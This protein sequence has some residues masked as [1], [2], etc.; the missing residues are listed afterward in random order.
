MQ[1]K[2]ERSGSWLPF[3]GMGLIGAMIAFDA[4]YGEGGA[5]SGEL[6]AKRP[7][8]SA[9]E[10]V[11]PSESKSSIAGAIEAMGGANFGT[12]SDAA[13]APAVDR[14]VVE[15]GCLVYAQLARMS[16]P[17]MPTPI[18][19]PDAS[20]VPFAR[21]YQDYDRAIAEIERERAPLLAAIVAHR[22]QSGEVE[23]L[24][25]PDAI[26]D[27]REAKS[28]RD[29]MTAAMLP[30]AEPQWIATSTDADWVYVVRIDPR[31]E[32]SLALVWAK[33]TAA[34]QAFLTAGAAAID[35]EARK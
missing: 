34:E 1:A 31:A 15:A 7:F 27:E 22:L 28:A 16:R 2:F 10:G 8:G 26:P 17:D 29:R 13:L 20:A 24:A 14:E 33:T 23:R 6:D 30:T 11:Q 4:S 19:I 5:A 32:P 35:A 9:N 3:L 12:A 18:R 21:S 25:R